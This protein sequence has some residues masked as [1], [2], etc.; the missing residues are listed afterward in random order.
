MVAG[1]PWFGDWSRDTMTSYEGLFLRTNRWDE[2]RA[3]LTRAAAGLSEGML[4]NTADNVTAWILD[5]PRIKPGVKMPALGLSEA[6]ARS[7]AA[8]LLSLE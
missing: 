7:I 6:Q 8:Y 5:P 1:Y 3:V 4:P 2:G